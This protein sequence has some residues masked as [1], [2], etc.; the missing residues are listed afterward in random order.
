MIY[1]NEFP[2]ELVRENRHLPYTEKDHEQFNH[3]MRTNQCVSADW[4]KED[5]HYRWLQKFAAFG[6]VLTEISPGKYLDASK[7]IEVTYNGFWRVCG[8][9]NGHLRG[10]GMVSLKRFTSSEQFRQLMRDSSMKDQK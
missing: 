8:K 3:A 4:V 10:K 2:T 6:M 9:G 5:R 7:V 1:D